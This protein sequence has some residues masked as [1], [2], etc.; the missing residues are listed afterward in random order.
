DDP[1][2]ADGLGEKKASGV[3]AGRGAGELQQQVD[4]PVFGSAL[5]GSA[6]SPIFNINKEEPETNRTRPP[7]PAFGNASSNSMG[8]AGAP[9]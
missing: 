7:V 1:S 9:A 6:E 8:G 5:K 2:F 4:S 3:P